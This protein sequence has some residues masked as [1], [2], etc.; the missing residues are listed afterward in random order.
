[1]ARE[2][3]L[4]L[5]SLPGW[6][7]AVLAAGLRFQGWDGIGHLCK[8]KSK[9]H[10]NMHYRRGQGLCLIRTPGTGDWTGSGLSWPLFECFYANS[11]GIIIDGSNSIHLD[12][13]ITMA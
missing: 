7:A 10:N 11:G 3:Y 8:S 13:I 1:M 12:G 2:D 6:N 5:I 4:E 9:T